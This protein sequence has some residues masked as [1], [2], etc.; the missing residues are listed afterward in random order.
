MIMKNCIVLILFCLALSLAAQYS[1]LHKELNMPAGK[2][3]PQQILKQFEKENIEISY[4]NSL[5]AKDSIKVPKEV[6]VNELIRLLFNP[7]YSEVLERNGKILVG[8]KKNVSVIYSGF[9]EEKGSG[10]RIIGANIYFPGL[11]NGTA[12]NAYGFFNISLADLE[13]QKVIVSAIGYEPYSALW[14][15]AKTQFDIQLQPRS[16]ELKTVEVSDNKLVNL[17]NQTSFIKLNQQQIQDL[18]AFFGEPDVLKAMHFLPGVQMGNE[19]N[20]NFLVR[21]GSADQNLILL[22]GVPVYNASH[23]FGFFSAFN[24]DAVKNVELT[25]GG[26]SAK[27]G[28]RLSSVL[29]I[30]TIEGDMQEFH[31]AGGIGIFSSDFTLQGPIV[32]NQTS[33]MISG[34]RTYQDWILNL[35]GDSPVGYYFGDLN[36]KL[37]HKFSRKDRLYLSYYTGKDDLNS[38]YE[39]SRFAFFWGNHTGVVRWNHLFNDQLFSNL[40]FNYSRYRLGAE[41]GFQQG[42]VFANNGYYSLVEDYG[43]RYDFE[44]AYNNTHRFDF[45]AS[46]TFHNIKPGLLTQ[47]LS[48]FSLDSVMNIAPVQ[49]THDAFLYFQDEWQITQR[50]NFT[51]GLHFATYQTDGKNYSSLQP[52]ASLLYQLSEKVSIKSSWASMQQFVHLLANQGTSL[53]TDIWVSSNRNIA[54]QKSWQIATGVAASLWEGGVSFETELY[55][56]NFSNLIGYK[57]AASVAVASNWEANVVSGGIGESFGLETLIRKNTGKITGWIGYTLSK[58]QRQFDELNEGDWFPFKFDRRHDFKLSLKY[59]PRKRFNVA[60]NFVYSTGMRG[61]VPIGRFYDASGDVGY[62]FTKRNA[63]LYP[64]YHRMDIA[65]NFPKETSWGQRTWSF[66][67]YNAYNRNNPFFV[68][69]TYGQRPHA[70]QLSLFPVLPY[71]SY[72]FKF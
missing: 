15:P 11:Q 54:P 67:A 5:L 58:S 45:G 8:Y 6:K 29:E 2:Y 21:G 25:K 4:P 44:Y 18:P 13:E 60:V 59:T 9:V 43:I 10:E 23:L 24:I 7:Q 52:R 32:K 22:D 55:Y 37:N 20:I 57:P 51:S 56:K 62:V 42:D 31:G 40:S 39:D 71:V 68:Y 27:H 69:F 41:F 33:F 50:L 63:F 12:T 35:M 64:D 3:T 19:G 16:F 46:Y 49:Q 47:S 70:N 72:Q 14:S 17:Q 36:V 66:G 61:T 53:P 34:R 65:F 38:E 48:T 30:N 1:P 26:F 28:G